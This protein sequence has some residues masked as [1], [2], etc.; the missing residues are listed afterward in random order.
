[1]LKR[2]F[3]ASILVGLLPVAAEAQ[4]ATVRVA[5]QVRRPVV[6]EPISPQ[7][8]QAED[9]RAAETELEEALPKNWRA[10]VR[11]GREEVTWILTP[12]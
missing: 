2:L 7:V 5:V 4:D 9:T 10:E 12:L 3:W 8:R 6:V 1:M 11:P